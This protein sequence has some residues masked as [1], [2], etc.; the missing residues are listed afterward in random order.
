MTRLRTLDIRDEQSVRSYF[1]Q[2]EREYPEMIET[3]RVM[4]I[5]YQEYLAAILAM[6]QQSSFS[7]ASAP[8][9]L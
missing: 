7:T 4:N 2:L 5:S 8:P 9:L 3:L 1:E 6:N